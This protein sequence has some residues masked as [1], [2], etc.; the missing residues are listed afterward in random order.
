MGR[1][2]DK[3]AEGGENKGPFYEM[4][5]WLNKQHIQCNYQEKD[6]RIWRQVKFGQRTPTTV[7]QF[8]V[9]GQD[10]ELFRASVS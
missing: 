6:P 1:T 8:L 4:L 9:L 10:I 3:K 2:T 5:I 7:N